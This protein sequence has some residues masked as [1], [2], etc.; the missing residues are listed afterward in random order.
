MPDDPLAATTVTLLLAQARA[1]DRGAFDR[2]M[3]LIYAELHRIAEQQMA[4]ERPGHT[5][6]PTALVHEAFLRLVGGEPASFNNRSHFLRAAATAMRHV[7]VD[8]ARK[9]R[10]AKREGVHITLDDG[11]IGAAEPAVDV[12][13]LNDALMRLAATEP[14]CAQ[15]VDLRFFAGLSIPE[16]ASALDTSVATVNR[17]WQF[18]RGWLA[19]EMASDPGSAR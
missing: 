15:V 10:A 2:L 9:R 5:L 14:R 11:V 7:L 13:A 8:H 19:H 3:P 16:V 4:R 6:Q 18:A 12:E 17:D 1:G